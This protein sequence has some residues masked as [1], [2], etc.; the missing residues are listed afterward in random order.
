MDRN[1]EYYQSGSRHCISAWYHRNGHRQQMQLKFS[2]VRRNGTGMYQSISPSTVR[3]VNVNGMV[4][5]W[6]TAV[7]FTEYGLVV[8]G[9]LRRS[10]ASLPAPRQCRD[11]NRSG[12]EGQTLTGRILPM[13]IASPRLDV[14]PSINTCASIEYVIKLYQ[15]TISHE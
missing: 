10:L 14:Y 1:T 11:G 6:G 9:R 3:S 2:V 12:I 15:V 4:E 7:A 8:S 5:G 13:N